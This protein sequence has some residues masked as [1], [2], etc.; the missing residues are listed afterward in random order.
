MNFYSI[1]KGKILLKKLINDD[2][3]ILKSAESKWSHNLPFWARYLK[4]F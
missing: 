1:V 2:A 4:D 3:S